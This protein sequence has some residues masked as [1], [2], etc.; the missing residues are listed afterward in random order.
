MVVSAFS[1]RRAQGALKGSESMRVAHDQKTY[2]FGLLHLQKATTQPRSSKQKTG[3]VE[4]K[5]SVT[6]TLKLSW[7]VSQAA[8]L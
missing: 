2:P 4:D 1:S 5:A 3:V 7:L 6:F 8:F